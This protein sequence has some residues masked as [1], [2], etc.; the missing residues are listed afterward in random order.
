MI[1]RCDR[2]GCAPGRRSRSRR[3]ERTSSQLT[4]VVSTRQPMG[5]SL[6]A[7]VRGLIS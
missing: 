2:A 5:L 4:L 6:T 3:V 7:R 1:R